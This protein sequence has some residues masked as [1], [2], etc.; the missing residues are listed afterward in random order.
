[1]PE[2]DGLSLIRRI[3]S[4]PPE[5]G[6]LVPAVALTAYV[7][8]AERDRALDAGFDS[9]LTKPIDPRVLVAEISK[10]LDV[11]DPERPAA[12]VGEVFLPIFH[13]HRKDP[14]GVKA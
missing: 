3:R 10:L 12:G 2:E 8:K 11:P 4:L 13:P 5:A 6:G 1:M 9:F 14:P 7:G